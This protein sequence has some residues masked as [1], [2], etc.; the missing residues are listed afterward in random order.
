LNTVD[1]RL[2]NVYGPRQATNDY[3]GVITSFIRRIQEG[4][5]PVIYGDGKQTRDFVHVSDVIQAFL[6]SLKSKKAIGQT[7]NIGSGNSV[8]INEIFQLIRRKFQVEVEPVYT[9]PR[10]G[11][12]RQSCAKIEKA[13]QMLGYE[14]KV[15]IEKGLE[16]LTGQR[17]CELE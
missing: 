4:K 5:P 10:L 2:F 16:E 14:P 9:E 7:F 17:M 6:L 1:L 11:D 13:R 3:S 15:P 8:T 12:I